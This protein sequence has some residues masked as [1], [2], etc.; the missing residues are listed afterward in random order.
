[1]YAGMAVHNT[2]EANISYWL[3]WCCVSCWWLGDRHCTQR[4]CK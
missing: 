2:N 3:P 1:M 4:S